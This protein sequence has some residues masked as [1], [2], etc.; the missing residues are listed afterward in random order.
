MNA[1]TTVGTMVADRGRALGL[2]ARRL[3]WAVG[4]VLLAAVPLLSATFQLYGNF[5]AWD[6]EG[7][8]MMTVGHFLRGYRLYDE[9]ASAY[10]PGYYGFEYLLHHGLGVPLTHDATRL[11]TLTVWATTAGVSAWIVRRLTGRRSL[12]VLT[13]VL[14]ATYLTSTKQEPGHPQELAALLTVLGVATAVA[15][16]RERPLWLGAGGG[17]VA[18]ALAL[19]KINLGVFATLSWIWALLAAAE[20]GW[21]VRLARWATAGAALLLPF[22]LLRPYLATAWGWNTALLISLVVATLALAGP[23][24]EGLGLRLKPALG[25][26]LAS[27]PATAGLLCLFV[28]AFGTTPLG[29]LDALV[30]SPRRMAATFV[31]PI[32][33]NNRAIGL[34][35][36]SLGLA[37]ERAHRLRS[38]R[39]AAWRLEEY[40]LVFLKVLFGLGI[41]LLVAIPTAG[42]GPLR[43]I[44]YGLPLLW[45][46]LDP[47]PAPARSG[48]SALAR[49]VLCCVAALQV[50]QIFPIPGSQCVI[51]TLLLVPAA[52]LCWDD[53]LTWLA[54]RCEDRAAGAAFVRGAPWLVVAAVVTLCAATAFRAYLRYRAATPL[55]LRGAEWIRIDERRVAAYRWLAANL[56]RHADTFLC[57]T[58]FNSLYLWTGLRPA[59]RI[60]L[61]N[62]IDYVSPEHQETLVTSLSRLPDACVIEHEP[63]LHPLVLSSIRH[64]SLLRDYIDQEF[65]VCGMVDGFAFRIRRGRP[66]PRLVDCARWGRAAGSA[67]QVTIDLAPS[68]GPKAHRVCISDL[69]H[70]LVLADSRPAGSGRAALMIQD[71]AGRDLSPVLEREGIDL[72]RLRSLTLSFAGPPASGRRGSCAVVRLYDRTGQMIKILPFLNEVEAGSV[73]SQTDSTALGEIASPVQPPSRLGREK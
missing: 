44:H 62:T 45:L 65:K 8:L 29:L 46:A 50:L 36:L 64:S 14:V 27:A 34:S 61:S 10:G 24:R 69:D 71:E 39:L 51:G 7:W 22:L 63:Y 35:L 21:W 57:T 15:A 38:G 13:F 56:E 5:A 26:F 3:A 37:A 49:L 33:I 58:G 9:I 43:I 66:V 48:D 67:C 59:C 16:G 30:L 55:G 23:G 25:A 11:I 4:L 72:S 6:D 41:L 20:G 53:V 31:F 28:F 60:G 73:Q 70:G 54:R 52:V 2:P 40:L 47:F 68:P 1:T 18:T 32:P 42:R 19:T 17:A 12:G